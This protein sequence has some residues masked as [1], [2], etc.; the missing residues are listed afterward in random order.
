MQKKKI[1]KFFEKKKVF[2]GEYDY[3][4][5]RSFGIEITKL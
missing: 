4:S 2:R 5:F 3:S 1:F